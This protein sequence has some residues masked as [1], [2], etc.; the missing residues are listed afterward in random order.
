MLVLTIAGIIVSCVSVSVSKTAN[1]L[2]DKSN[3]INLANLELQKNAMLPVLSY[4]ENAVDESNNEQYYIVNTGDDFFNPDYNCYS[5]LSIL[6]EGTGR[7]DKGFYDKPIYIKYVLPLNISVDSYSES[8]KRFLIHI[9]KE[10]NIEIYDEIAIRIEFEIKKRGI[11]NFIVFPP[12]INSYIFFS[13]NDKYLKERH[14]DGYL[15]ED[16]SYISMKEKLLFTDIAEEDKIK[17]LST[18]IIQED[19]NDCVEISDNV[20]NVAMEQFEKQ[21]YATDNKRYFLPGDD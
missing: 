12:Q 21:Y 20:I 8:E 1:V 19:D 16:M 10:Q 6:V 9:A 4:V 18:I 13:Y 7:D 14:T 2:S 17:E 15:M 11:R 5:V 3:D